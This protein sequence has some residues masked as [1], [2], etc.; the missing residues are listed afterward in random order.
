MKKLII[1]LIVLAAI[2]GAGY[3][4]Y[5]YT[6]PPVET[7]LSTLPVSRGDVVE[8]VGAT[9]TLQAVT[10]VVVGSQVSGQ[11]KA[12]YADFNQIVNK[13]QIIAELDPSLLQT[14]IE[15][16]RA[17]LARSQADLDR[18]KVSLEDA[19]TKLKRSESLAARK[20]VAAQDLE[21]AQMAVR[22]AEA[23]VKSSEASL[24]QS[25]ASLSQAE[26]N[27]QHTVIEAPITGIVIERAVDVGQT[28]AASMNAPTLFTIAADLS[29]MQVNASVD[30]SDVARI[31]PG[32][33]VKF[34]VDA[35]PDEFLGAI[36]QVRL[37]P[38][39]S[40]NVVTYATVID[41]PNPQF[42]L[43]PGMTANVTIEIARRSDVMRVPAAA[44]R[45]RPTN[46]IFAA[47]NQPVPPEMQR[48][49]GRGAAGSAVGGGSRGAQGGASAPGAARGGTQAP[50]AAPGASQ[51]QGAR[52]L[53]QPSGQPG[54]QPGGGTRG[55]QTGTP[56][57]AGGRG[58][59]GSQGAGQWAGGGQTSDP[60]ARRKAFQ[61]RMANMTPEERAQYEERM[62]ARGMDPNN[63][64]FG[65]GQGQGQGRGQGGA[66]SGMRGGG[67][68]GERVGS[69][70]PGLDR[71]NAAANPGAAM[72]GAAAQTIDQLFGPLPVTETQGRAWIYANGQI[73]SVRLRLGISDGT[74]Y[75]LLSGEIQAGQ[76]LVTAIITPAMAAASATRSPLMPQSGMPG[77]GGQRG[78]MPGGG[79]ARGGAGSH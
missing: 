22:M 12:L 30:E 63:P 74:F 34:R 23:Q 60:E 45:F 40:Q 64:T 10:T 50:G 54:G 43:K 69:G 31:R 29:K 3:S 4:Y 44:I 48:G 67:Q 35:Y 13:G 28:V 65:Q 73:K 41:V 18:L 33:V 20:L 6:N 51:S 68:P 42:K 21:A 55:A 27:L 62:R 19:K 72:T 24:V 61:E 7:K 58:G 70:F 59:D 32:Q 17:N 53:G 5:K 8:S 2:A 56:G 79:G 39:V 26:V 36:S 14:Q 37:K 25:Q 16:N 78:G 57:A 1:T 76:E 38:I 11:I 46:D 77:M 71:A 15:S 49:A 52:G 47:L 66:P 75:E 9:G